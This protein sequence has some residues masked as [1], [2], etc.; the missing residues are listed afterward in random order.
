[1]DTVLRFGQ[2]EL[3]PTA[4]LLRREGTVVPLPPKALDLLWLL[5]RQPGT[6][7]TKDD[8]FRAIWPDVA[9]TDNALTQVV[10]DLRQAL[11]ETPDAPQYIQT[12]ARRGYR[13]VASVSG[14]RPR[15]DGGQTLV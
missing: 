11:G 9:V 14:V 12:V 2:F 3:D 10:S 13:F 4:Y 8:I 6:L 15:S 5:A 7:L 1:M